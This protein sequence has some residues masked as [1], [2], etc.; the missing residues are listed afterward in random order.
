MVLPKPSSSAVSATMT[1]AFYTRNVH[2]SIGYA[3]HLKIVKKKNILDL[4]APLE[5]KRV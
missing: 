5:L 2:H 3:S 1:A 4:I